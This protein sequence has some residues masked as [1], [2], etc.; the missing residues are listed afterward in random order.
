ML[1]MCS[2]LLCGCGGSC[3][4][5]GLVFPKLLVPCGPWGSGMKPSALA[6]GGPSPPKPSRAG[7]WLSC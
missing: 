3:S 4:T 2:L 6:A 5:L 7:F 1:A